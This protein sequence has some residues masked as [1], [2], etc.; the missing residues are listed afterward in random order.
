MAD[1]KNLVALY[2][3]Y[4]VVFCCCLENT[5]CNLTHVLYKSSGSTHLNAQNLIP[6]QRS[7]DTTDPKNLPLSTLAP[8]FWLLII[9]GN[10]SSI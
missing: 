9:F 5:V 6:W 3:F 2:F 8:T 10:L 7:C 4:F 1:E